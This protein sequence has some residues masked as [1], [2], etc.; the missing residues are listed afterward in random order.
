MCHV[1]A[2]VVALAMLVSKL[3]TA[4]QSI[5]EI[6]ALRSRQ[7]TTARRY[8][9]AHNVSTE[10]AMSVRKHV[11]WKQA[12]D[13]TIDH[14]RGE[15]ELLQI[16]PVELRRALCDE[17]RS[18]VLRKHAVFVA[19]RTFSL[20][21]FQSL[22]CDSMHPSVHM[23]DDNIFAYGS[24]CHHMYF[25]V[26]G[27]ASYMKYGAVLQVL[28]S[29]GHRALRESSAECEMRDKYKRLRREPISDGHSLC[30]P[31]I[32]VVWKHRGDFEALNH[33]SLLTLDTTI[34][35]DL[36]QSYPAVQ[37]SVQEH[38][39]RFLA[40]LNASEDVL[41]DLFNTGQILES[42]L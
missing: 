35:E 18:P 10:L 24:V 38:A 14:R 8:L 36:V 42:G 29:S 5:E 33:T 26:T 7:V 30:E 32:W 25:I 6:K 40:A 37:A 9:E 39:Q 17:T 34:F 27:D 31:A 3:T 11:E 19:F 1:L 20:K 21:F 4:M 2:S 16:L 15:S 23:P 28:L 41:S 12:V 13:T 22:C